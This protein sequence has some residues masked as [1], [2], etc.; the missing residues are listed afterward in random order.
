MNSAEN[1][2]RIVQVALDNAYRHLICK[3]IVTKR[4]QD[5]L[6]SVTSKERY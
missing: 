2:V 6:P 4:H 1:L 5:P 3:G